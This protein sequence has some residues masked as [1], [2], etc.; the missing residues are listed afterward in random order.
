MYTIFYMETLVL[1]GKTYVKASKA[2]RDL[3]YATDY[4]GQLCRSG[5]V[6]AHLI[7]RTW[8]VDATE[9]GTHRIE[10]KRISR[11]K[12]REQAHKSIDEHRVKINSAPN[13]YKNIGIQYEQDSEDLIP[14]TKKLSVQ[15]TVSGQP[16]ENDD[17][18]TAPTIINK[19][20]KVLMSGDIDVVDVTDG[21][22]D[23]DT[24]VLTPTAF[25]KSPAAPKK[26]VIQDDFDENTSNENEEMDEKVDFSQKLEAYNVEINDD[27]NNQSEDIEK[28]SDKMSST[29]G[30]L[31]TKPGSVLPYIFA[32]LAILFV[33]ILSIPLSISMIYTAENTPHVDTSYHYSFDKAL[34]LLQ[35]KI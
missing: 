8:Y 2:A 28:V 33:T 16:I 18:D 15:S 26:I 17:F 23:G 10:K 11:V 29:K 4:V 25:R 27:P 21:V 24:T 6:P 22:I 31:N 13:T 32:T 34:I 19:G 14:Q 30:E 12:A 5:K 9:L 7:G 3:G 20:E 1:D 35:L